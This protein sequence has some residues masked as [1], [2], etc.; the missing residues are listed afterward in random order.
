M[1]FSPG[2][3]RMHLFDNGVLNRKPLL[4]TEDTEDTEKKSSVWRFQ[5]R[6]E[7]EP[8]VLRTV[9]AGQVVLRACVCRFFGRGK[10][11][12]DAE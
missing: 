5:G 7:A 11:R 6:L 3:L 1:G 9:E 2:K 8:G 10:T 12:N 4:T